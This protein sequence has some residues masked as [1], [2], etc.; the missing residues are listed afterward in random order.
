MEYYSRIFHDEVIKRIRNLEKAV[1]VEAK[2]YVFGAGL[3]LLLAAD[4]AIAAENT[5]FSSGFARIGLS[6]N[7]GSSFFFPRLVGLRGHLN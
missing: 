3:S 5:I 4:Y 1:I 7:T 6:P 2:G